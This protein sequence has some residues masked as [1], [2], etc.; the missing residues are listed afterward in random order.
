MT[1]LRAAGV[2]DAEFESAATKSK[3]VFGDST[4]MIL[5]IAGQRTIHG[6]G[7]S[8]RGGTSCR[9]RLDGHPTRSAV[10]GGQPI[11][12]DGKE[13]PTASSDVGRCIK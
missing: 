11:S 10:L 2:D 6:D 8:G 5:L 1:F 4:R 9:P 7:M 12:S 13:A 3:V